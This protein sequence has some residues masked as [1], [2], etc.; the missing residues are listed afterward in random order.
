M[1]HNQHLNLHALPALY[2]TARALASYVVPQEC[3]PA[4]PARMRAGSPSHWAATY[5]TTHRPASATIHGPT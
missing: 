4:A 3:A 2:A 5:V 1:L